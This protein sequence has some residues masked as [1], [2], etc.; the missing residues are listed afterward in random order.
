[1]KK[2]YLSGLDKNKVEMV[3]L[4]I[5][6]DI[7][8]LFKIFILIKVKFTLSEMCWKFNCFKFSAIKNKA[9]INIP[10]CFWWNPTL[11]APEHSKASVIQKNR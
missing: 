7:L 1:M 5:C 2:K 10:V 9:G 6:N 3:R 8:L 11:Q 4:Y